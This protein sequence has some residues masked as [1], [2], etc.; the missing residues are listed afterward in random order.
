MWSC[1]PYAT[2]GDVN[3]G[4]GV[5]SAAAPVSCLIYSE[6]LEAL[7]V[8]DENGKSTLFFYVGSPG[9]ADSDD[10]GKK[11]ELG[12]LWEKRVCCSVGKSPISMQFGPTPRLLSI[13]F[14]THLTLCCREF[15]RN[16]FRGGSIALQISLEKVVIEHLEAPDSREIEFPSMQISGLDIS[17]GHVLAWDGNLAKVAATQGQGAQMMWSFACSATCMAAHRDTVFC[18][19]EARLEART[20]TGTVK[21]TMSFEKDWGSPIH[22]DASEDYLAVVTDRQRAKI[23]KVGGRECKPVSPAVAI[24][25]DGDQFGSVEAM[26]V[27]CNGTK[28][29]FLATAKERPT[30]DARVFVLD[31]ESGITSSHDFSQ[32]SQMPEAMFWDAHEASLLAVQTSRAAS[33][34]SKHCEAPGCEVATFFATQDHGLISHDIQALPA[35]KGLVGIDAPHLLVFSPPSSAKADTASGNRLAVATRMGCFAGVQEISQNTKVG[36]L[37]FSC[38][39]SIGATEEAVKAIEKIQDPAVWE[40]M[41]QLCIRNGRLDVAQLCLGNM[42][43]VRV[44]RA[45]RQTENSM[46]LEARVGT[47]AVHIGM[48]GDAKRLLSKSERFDLLN[49]VLQAS[50]NWEKAMEIA[51]DKDRIHLKATHYKLAKQL[52]LNK[53]YRGAAQEYTS[54]GRHRKEVPRMLYQSGNIEELE[55]YIKG[56]GDRELLRWWA[57]YLESQGDFAGAMRHYQE[58]EDIVAAVRTCAFTGDLAKAED[59]AR[60][61][62]H[63]GAMF[64]MARQYEAQGA[65]EEAIRCYSVAKRYRQGVRLA[66][67]YGMDQELMSLALQS[68][69]RVMTEAADYF[70]ARQDWDKAVQLYHKGGQPKKALEL[71]VKGHLSDALDNIIGELDTDGDPA[72]LSSVGSMLLQRGEYQ[73][74]ARLFLRVGDVERALDMCIRYDVLITEDIAEAMS[75]AAPTSST[76][77]RSTL[78]S[79][80]AKV[81]K[82]QGA[83]SLAAKKYAEA[84]E[85]LKSMKAL[86]KARDTDKIVFF[87]G[88]CRQREAY[89]MAANYLRTL[90]WHGDPSLMKHIVSYYTKGRAHDSLVAFYE[91]CAQIEIDEY[92]D[93]DKACQAMREALRHAEKLPSGD[94]LEGLSQRL[95]AMERFMSQACLRGG[96]VYALMVEYWY[97]KGDVKQAFELVQ[98]M[99][100][101]NIALGPYIDRSMLEAIKQ[102]AGVEAPYSAFGED[103]DIIEEDM[104]PRVDDDDSE[105]DT[106]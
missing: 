73:K 56:S 4:C 102:A 6:A 99:D 16:R 90:D 87:A 33:R 45:L 72:L 13:Q 69:P 93:Y 83:F 76:A 50:G 49:D 23:F 29:S 68:E 39:L 22:V 21:Q 35:G 77:E 8:A 70:H 1:S 74:A 97:E 3:A 81:C 51:G 64:Y 2:C 25:F 75:S 85:R 63:A 94:L 41:A 18:I 100:G 61:T 32:S 24:V 101:R 103:G 12:Q 95:E 59:I 40:N 48:V 66:L 42:E 44:S 98:R 78:L 92:R 104:R 11:D 28:V 96:D 58:A 19:G 31:I 26:R 88:V 43:H 91:A 79:R 7:A 57:R 62:G 53:D 17:E 89:L 105:Y 36:L 38:Q 30:R 47:A 60:E 10:Q 37:E 54:A 20:V 106:D 84:G 67:Q 65:V 14:P 52:E 82:H 27:N 80:I 71:C 5:S 55:R 86:I 34:S 15:L 46:R 9:V